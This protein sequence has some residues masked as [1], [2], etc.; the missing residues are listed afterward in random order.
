MSLGGIPL[1]DAAIGVWDVQAVLPP[2]SP[3]VDGVLSLK[4][5]ASHPFS[6]DLAG[7]RLTLETAE[8]FRLQVQTM[9]RLRSRIATGTD[10]DETLFVR[11]A[12]A[13]IPLVPHRQ[14]QPRRGTGGT[15]S[16]R[17]SLGAE[18]PGKQSRLWTDFPAAE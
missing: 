12:A 5:L 8:S 2:G 17:R 1:A 9:T 13:A 14:R 11:G 18:G 16:E 10:G 6:L 7:R 4:T 15:A 3:P